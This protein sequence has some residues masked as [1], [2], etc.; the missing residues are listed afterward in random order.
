MKMSILG[1]IACAIVLSAPT[2]ASAA[3]DYGCD[4]VN[5][6]PEVI[7]KLPNAK[8]LCRGVMEKNNGVYVKY[9]ARVVSS[10]PDST[11]VEFLDKDEKAVSRATFKPGEGQMAEVN[12]KKVKYSEVKKGTELHFYIEHNRW[13]LFASPDDKAMSILSVEQL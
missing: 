3:T 6:S 13:G 4:A 5:F 10:S 2:I 12:G 11:T 7:A 9:V 1:A 8:R